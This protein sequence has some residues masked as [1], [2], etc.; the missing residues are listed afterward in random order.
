MLFLSIISEVIILLIWTS[1][2]TL[3]HVITGRMYPSL[4]V[5]GCAEGFIYLDWRNHIK[6]IKHT[7]K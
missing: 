6:N 1:E 5:T 3:A 4:T 7:D 2:S